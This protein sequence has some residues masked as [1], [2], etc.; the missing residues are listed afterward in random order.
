MRQEYCI[1]GTILGRR[2]IIAMNQHCQV[3]DGGEWRPCNYIKIN[4]SQT[5]QSLILLFYMNSLS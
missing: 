3:Y 4:Q 1:G 2:E 5:T